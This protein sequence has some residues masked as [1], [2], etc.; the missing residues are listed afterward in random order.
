MA[1]RMRVASFRIWDRD[2]SLSPRHAERRKRIIWCST[3]APST[4]RGT[5]GTEISARV[6]GVIPTF[7]RAPTWPDG[8]PT[9][10]RPVHGR[11][12]HVSGWQPDDEPPAVSYNSTPI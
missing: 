4:V 10:T 6:S 12:R 9:P 2:S 8:F 7:Y 11:G 5:G 3:L 1:P